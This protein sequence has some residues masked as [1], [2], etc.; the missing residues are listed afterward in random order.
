MEELQRQI[1]ALREELNS[2]KNSSTIPFDIGEAF[3][4]R[5]ETESATLNGTSTASYIQAV[6][7]SGSATYNVAKPMNGFL[8]IKVGGVTYKVPYYS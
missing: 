5:L 4:D 2:L 7:E 8:S 3:R 6:N 1:E